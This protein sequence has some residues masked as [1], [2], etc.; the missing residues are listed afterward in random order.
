MQLKVALLAEQ[1]ILYYVAYSSDSLPAQR[2]ACFPDH[3]PERRNVINYVALKV[4]SIRYCG[5][6]LPRL[7]QLL[8]NPILDWQIEGGSG[9]SRVEGGW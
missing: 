4:F 7:E 6:Q 1:I 2:V 8:Q 5:Y 3:P 9:K